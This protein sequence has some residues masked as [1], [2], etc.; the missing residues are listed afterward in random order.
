MLGKA[1]LFE[2]RKIIFV[3]DV[4]IETIFTARDTQF[5]VR[6]DDFHEVFLVS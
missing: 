1:L 3:L 2:R 6:L 4:V 5:V